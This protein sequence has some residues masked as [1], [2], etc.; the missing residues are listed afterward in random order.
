[1][2]YELTWGYGEKSEW[3]D[4]LLLAANSLR[5]ARR[6]VVENGNTQIVPTMV[7]HAQRCADVLMEGLMAREIDAIR[8][9]LTPLVSNFIEKQRLSDTP[10]MCKNGSTSAGLMDS[11]TNVFSPESFVDLVT[12]KFL[13]EQTADLSRP[14]IVVGPASV[15]LLLGGLLTSAHSRSAMGKTH[16]WKLGGIVT[17]PSD[18]PDSVVDQVPAESCFIPDAEPDC[19]V[20]LIEDIVGNTLRRATE[21]MHACFPHLNLQF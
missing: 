10:P 16:A 1:M 12:T 13:H 18:F 19:P 4:A 8:E 9:R 11:L 6:S 17:N 14:A 2:D 7:D 15:G 21:T 3:V 5:S 20:Y